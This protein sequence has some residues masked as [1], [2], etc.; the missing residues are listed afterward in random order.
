M[1]VKE[2]QAA[3]RWN[4]IRPPTTTPENKG[5]RAPANRSSASTFQQILQKQLGNA[6]ELRFSS[7]AMQRLRER[8]LT[9]SPQELNRLLEGVSKVA[10]KGGRQSVILVDDT[11]YVVSVKNRTVVTAMEKG[12]AQENVFTNIDSVAIV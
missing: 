1:Q 12:A 9:P 7:H 3:V 5:V 6:G 11:A 2:W 4:A 8:N 10:A